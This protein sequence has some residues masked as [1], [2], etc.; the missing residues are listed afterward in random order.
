MKKAFTLAELAV[1]SVIILVVLTALAVALFAFL[2]GS[3]SLE[4]QEGAFTLARVEIAD[5]E[6]SEVIPR[7]GTATRPD[8]LWGN[9]YSVETAVNGSEAGFRDV[10]VTVSSGDTVAIEL[11]RRFYDNDIQ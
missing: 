9:P 7:P 11:T 1:A 6:R 5:I 8:S 10:T 3:R 2:R 4:L